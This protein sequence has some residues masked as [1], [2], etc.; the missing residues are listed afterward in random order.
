MKDYAHTHGER[1]GLVMRF[2]NLSTSARWSLVVRGFTIY[3][4]GYKLDLSETRPPLSHSHLCPTI[5]QRNI[6][7]SFPYFP[8][9]YGFIN[10]LSLHPK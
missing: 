9:S 4:S 2:S 7:I 10:A 8:Y 1:R 6:E 5:P 3:Q